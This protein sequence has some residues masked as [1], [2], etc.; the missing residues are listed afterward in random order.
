MKKK[1]Q[2]PAG[3]GR[4]RAV[5]EV[6]FTNH[7]TARPRPGQSSRPEPVAPRAKEGVAWPG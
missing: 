1:M 7:H 3:L 4:A 2:T 6:L 5:T